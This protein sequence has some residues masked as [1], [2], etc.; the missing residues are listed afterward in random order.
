LLIAGDRDLL[1]Q[2]PLLADAP[3]P[4]VL[5]AWET[6]APDTFPVVTVDYEQAG[7][8]AGRHMRALGHERVAVVAS[9]AHGMRIQGFRRAFAEEGITVPEEAIHWAETPTPAGGHAAALAALAANPRTTGMFATHDTLALGALEAARA[10]G[11]NVP[12]DLSLVGHDDNQMV[13]LTS[14]A[15]TTVAIPKRE[16]GRQAISLLMR[17][18][19]SP[20]STAP[21]VHL[22]QPHLVVRGSTAPAPER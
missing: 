16:M 3:F 21:A 6:K 20:A 12:G 19:A 8:L 18:I 5:C 22:V 2:L 7:Y 17:A 1:D 13:R 9:P 15:L 4:V 14:P 11:R 10:A